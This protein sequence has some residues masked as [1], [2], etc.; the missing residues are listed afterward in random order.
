MP[1]RKGRTKLHNN[2]PLCWPP[3]GILPHIS[4]RQPDQNQGDN[5]E[6]S[7]H[8]SVRH[9]P[10]ITELKLLG[11]GAGHVPPL[12]RNQHFLQSDLHIHHLTGRRKQE[13]EVQDSNS[14]YFQHRGPLRC[15]LVLHHPQLRS[16]HA[17]VLRDSHP[18]NRP[19]LLF[20]LRRHPHQP[21]HQT[22][23]PISILK[24]PLH[25]PIQRY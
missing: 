6:R 9:S 14:F 7:H 15:P 17:C 13:A 12:N 11:G 2:H 24:T 20:L 23:S 3:P 21:H 18:R 8:S 1:L 4:A 16:S 10:A 5:A 22:P 19:R 25:C